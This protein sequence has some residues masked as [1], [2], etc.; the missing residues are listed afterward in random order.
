MKAVIIGGGVI[1]LCSAYYLQKT[2][3]QVT[4]LDDSRGD[5][6]CSYGNLGMIVPSHFV[7]LSSPGAIAKGV[8]W[9]FDSRSPFY[10]KFSFDPRLISWALRFVRNATRQNVEKAAIP[11]VEF[12]LYS[13]S[14]FEELNAEP[15]LDFGLEHT[16]ILMYYKSQKAADEEM[17]LARKAGE[18]GIDVEIL[19]KDEVQRLEP[20]TELD[21]L[22]AAHYRCDAHL[23]PNRFMVQL[24]KCLQVSG[25]DVQSNT[26]VTQ[27]IASSGRIQKVITSKGEQE[28]DAYVLA[29]GAWLGQLAKRLGLKIPLIAGKGYSFTYERPLK[30]LNFPAILCEARVAISPMCERMRYGG[31]MEVGSPDNKINMNR[32]KGIV[33]SI[34]QY[35]PD[36]NLNVPDTNDIWYGLRPCSPD[37]LPYVGR[38]SKFENLLIAGGHCMM[39]MSLG[40]ATGK[41]IADLAN[42]KKTHV[43]IRAFEPSRFS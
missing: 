17:H 2:G 11:L 28:G 7:P 32:V 31:T 41:S 5:E 16:G 24:R 39:G 6:G 29:C 4:V 30:K 36:F 14:L 15:G 42:N 33:E 25:V 23:D 19:N 43:D 40:P 10:I 9:L 8:R 3:W 27:I 37:G 1:G 26:S 12:N 35:L 34:S 21:V 13:Q 20:Q 38:S 22:G 18:L